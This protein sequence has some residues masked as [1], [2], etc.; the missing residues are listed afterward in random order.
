MPLSMME[1]KAVTRELKVRYRRSS[2]KEKKEILDE[3]C[4]LTGYNRSY[5]ARA[6]R[7]HAAKKKKTRKE[8]ERKYGDE[9]LGP[10]KKI[11]ATMD[12]IC[13]KRLKPFMEEIVERLEEFGE[14]A[15][16]DG[17]RRK[18]LSISPATIDRLLTKER[19][20]FEL[21]GRSR[22]KPGSLLKSQIPVKTFADWNERR[23]GFVEID[24]VGHEGGSAG[25]EF[26]QTLDVTDVF[27][28]WTETRAVKNKVRAWVFEA[29]KDI[30]RTLPFPLLGIDSDNGGEFINAH[31]LGFCEDKGITFTRSLPTARTTHVTL[32]RRTTRW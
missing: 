5:A 6:L 16:D 27:S 9:V 24:L 2:K 20:K 8:K 28:G 11:W 21:K 7:I 31:L 23:P 14:I 3:F 10:L 25:G 22:T 13:G 1:R 19:K 17:I 4:S 32:R 30:E 18:L 15:L 29:L 26:A 12:F